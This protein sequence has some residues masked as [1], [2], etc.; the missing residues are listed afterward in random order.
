MEAFHLCSSY[1]HMARVCVKEDNRQGTDSLVYL[2]EAVFVNK[3]S[4]P[5]ILVL[6]DSA[7]CC[8]TVMI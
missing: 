2:H 5:N 4:A 3:T 6:W 8:S 7:K 1:K